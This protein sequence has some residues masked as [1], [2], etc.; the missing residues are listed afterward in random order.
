MAIARDRLGKLSMANLKPQEIADYRDRRLKKIQS[1]TMNRELQI[2]SA[3]ITHS[4]REWGVALPFNPVAHVRKPPPG[5]HRNRVL[6]RDEEHKLMLALDGEGY[7][8]VPRT[9]HNCWV[10]PIIQLALETA[11]RRGE[12]L[13]MRWENVDLERRVIYLPL[14]KNGEDRNVPLSSQAIRILQQ[15]PRSDEGNVFPIAWTAL[16][17]AFRKACRRAGIDNLKFHDLRHTATTR[18]ASLLPNVIELSA[19][20]GH[21][22][23][24]M[25]KRY[26]HVKPEEL[27]RKLG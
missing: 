8:R 10:K 11:C 26:Y 19:V 9:H 14:T 4:I 24:A 3:A 15:L 7:L 27:A 1:S 2:I 6:E 5:V 25:L 23:L 17:Q 12:I 22:S 16:H 20:T 18:M 13:S 21:K